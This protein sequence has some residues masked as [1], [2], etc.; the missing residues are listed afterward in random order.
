MQP[1][2][3]TDYENLFKET[4]APV[5]AEDDFEEIKQFIDYLYDTNSDIGFAEDS[6]ASIPIK[7]LDQDLLQKYLDFSYRGFVYEIMETHRGEEIK[8]IKGIDLNEDV[9]EVTDVV[10]LKD[11][12][13]LVISGTRTALDETI[14]TLKDT[15]DIESVESLT[16]EEDAD[17]VLSDEETSVFEI[18]KDEIDKIVSNYES[19]EDAPSELPIFWTVSV[20]QNT[21]LITNILSFEHNNFIFKINSVVDK[22]LQELDSITLTVIKSE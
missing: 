11:G 10:H 22:P 1:Q 7:L 20:Y 21:A 12:A 14:Q 17:D 4:H 9:L 16:L 6:V 13:Q 18:I 5:W 15:V 8:L 2:D 3:W 19:Y